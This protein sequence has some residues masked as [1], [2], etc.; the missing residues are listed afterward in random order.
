MK[1]ITLPQLEEWIGELPQTDATIPPEKRE[2]L[3]AQIHPDRSLEHLAWFSGGGMVPTT[4][5]LELDSTR[6]AG[7]AMSGIRASKSAPFPTSLF[8]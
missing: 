8:T 2:G 5:A 7:V 3:F 1:K 4:Y 6:E